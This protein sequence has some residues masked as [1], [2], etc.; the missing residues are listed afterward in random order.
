MPEP[1]YAIEARKDVELESGQMNFYLTVAAAL[2]LAPFAAEI[3]TRIYTVSLPTGIRVAWWIVLPAAAALAGVLFYGQ[4]SVVSDAK[5]NLI[6]AIREDARNAETDQSNYFKRLVSIN[7]EN[8]AAYYGLVKSHTARSFWAALFA[9]LIAFLA[10][11]YAITV[12][13]HSA[14][15]DRIKGYLTALAPIVTQFIAGLFFYLYNRTVR[16]LQGYFNGLLGGQKLL[17]AFRCVEEA[18]DDEKEEMLRLVLKGLMAFDLSD[19]PP[20]KRAAG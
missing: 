3:F 19:S 10:L 7:V 15:Q 4:R 1:A 14:E 12:G 5:R 17:L 6:R 18:K 11:M 16:Q 8:L 2:L 13:F 20:I 9:S